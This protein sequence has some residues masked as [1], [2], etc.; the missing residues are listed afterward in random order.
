MLRIGC[1]KYLTVM[2]LVMAATVTISS[3][4]HASD[5]FFSCDG[6][7]KP[8]PNDDM[9]ATDPERGQTALW[10]E[11]RAWVGSL[12]EQ[13]VVA[14][15]IALADS[16]LKPTYVQRR[17]NLLQAK[18]AHL[19]GAGRIDD[20]LAN[21][22]ASDRVGLD[23]PAKQFSQ[24]IGLGNRIL[25]G[26]A[27]SLTGK[28]E[29]AAGE[30]DKALLTRPWASSVAL[31]AARVLFPKSNAAQRLNL[32]KRAAVLNPDVSIAGMA[33][34]LQLGDFQ[35]ANAMGVGPAPEPLPVFQGYR[36]PA[37]VDTE[38]RRILRNADRTG[39]HAYALCALAR[40]GEARAEMDAFE[41]SLH[42]SQVS[43]KTQKGPTSSA[44]STVHQKSS[45]T[46]AAWRQLIVLRDEI[47]NVPLTPELL[48][49][50]GEEPQQ[51][52]IVLSD[53]LN[54]TARSVGSKRD[55]AIATI[56]ET[57]D[58][59]LLKQ[60]S[61]QINLDVPAEFYALPDVETSIIRVRYRPTTKGI[62]SLG[63]GFT[64]YNTD[65]IDELGIS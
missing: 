44:L 34:A 20:A 4:A 10:S 36:D 51:V 5:P 32:L 46:I 41:S 19:L 29:D 25:R 22:E 42:Q 8:G 16:R 61:T 53:L 47:K 52:K 33:L 31:Q 35:T 17:A 48:A 65:K 1:K 7:K 28:I 6:L 23:Y 27:L 43:A 9:L 55:T 64:V 49:R 30:L 14:C 18:A 58:S 62:L 13:G 45:A 59:A 11:P 60:G 2:T 39:M 56:V 54:Q 12:D 40:C 37:S 15:D 50:L 63:S 38:A 57:N 24:G 26:I 21:L 3:Q